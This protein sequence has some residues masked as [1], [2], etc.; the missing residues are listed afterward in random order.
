MQCCEKVIAPLSDF[1]V[2]LHV[3][4]SC[5]FGIIKRILVFDEEN[6]SKYKMLLL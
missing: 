3:C 4:H 6:L 5:V 1:L 2:F